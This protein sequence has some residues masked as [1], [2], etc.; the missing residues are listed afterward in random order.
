MTGNNANGSVVSKCNTMNKFQI[1]TIID[2]TKILD[3]KI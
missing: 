1:L 3:L 2:T